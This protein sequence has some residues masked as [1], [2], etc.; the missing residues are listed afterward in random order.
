MLSIKESVFAKTRTSSKGTGTYDSGFV[1]LEALQ[2]VLTAAKNA[3]L[4]AVGMSP[5][6]IQSPKGWKGTIIEIVP[7]KLKA[8]TA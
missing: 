2:A 4:D 5:K 3:G 1:T 7:F 8:K 6:Q